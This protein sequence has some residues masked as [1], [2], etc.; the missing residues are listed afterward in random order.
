MSPRSGLGPNEAGCRTSVRPCALDAVGYGSSVGSRAPW[1][2]HRVV[3]GVIVLT[4]LLLAATPRLGAAAPSGVTVSRSTLVLIGDSISAGL[5]KAVHHPGGTRAEDATWTISSQPGAGWGEGENPR[6]SWPLGI[7][8]GDWAADEVR[9]AARLHPTTIAIELGTN[10]ALRA[11]FAYVTDSPV[12]LAARLTGTDENINS[13]VRLA[14]SVASC[15]VLVTPSYY[16]PSTFGSG[17]AVLGAS[18]PH[19]RGPHA[20]G[21]ADA[22]PCR[23]RR[24]LG[25]SVSPTPRSRSCEQLVHERR[26]PPQCTRGAGPGRSH[27]SD[28]SHLLLIM[29]RIS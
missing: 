15:V 8:H 23:G 29:P 25:G 20:A 6:G 27:H 28:G 11:A 3:T 4:V 9:A 16:P 2:A 13:V 14:G 24:R 5:A 21:D 1:S 7:V 22:S 17:G 12:S 19:P 18:T 10:D 26:A